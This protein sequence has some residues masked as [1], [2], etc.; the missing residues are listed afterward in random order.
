[1]PEY[2]FPLKDR[3]EVADGTM[4]FWFDTTGSNFTFSAGQNCLFTLLDPPKTDMEGDSRT[5]SIANSP[6]ERG[7]IMVATRMRP[8]AFKDSLASIP[9]GTKVR[10]S[11]PMGAFT[12]H[13]DQSRPA[14][15]LAGGIG[16]TPM[17][18]IIAWATAQ[19]L[20]HK[21]Y[22][23]YSNRNRAATA[24]LDDFERMASQNP[25]F[26]LIATITEGAD[27][28]WRH[29]VGRIDEAM[30]RRY[31]PDLA[32]AIYYVSGPPGM[33]SAMMTLAQGVGASRED[34]KVE[35]FAGYT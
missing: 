10:V 12:L 26:K 14:V 5:F 13:Q 18:S 7:S 8:T 16:I 6:H 25:N 9:L 34:I 19:R 29:Q 28:E 24:F 31:V 32:K 27:S 22:L 20:P 21:L 30:L 17:R 11:S 2:M 23:F 3:R 15:F 4:A 1:M 35:E 33:V